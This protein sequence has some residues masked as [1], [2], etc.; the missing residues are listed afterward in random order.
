MNVKIGNNKCT[1]TQLLL[2]SFAV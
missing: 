1:G 2:D